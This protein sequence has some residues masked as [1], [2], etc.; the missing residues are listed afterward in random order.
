MPIKHVAETTIKWYDIEIT[1]TALSRQKY[2]NWGSY[3][4]TYYTCLMEFVDRDP[5]TGHIYDREIHPV[6]YCEDM[7]GWLYYRDDK[8]YP[9][10]YFKKKIMT[11]WCSVP[12]PVN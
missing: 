6:C 12:D 1:P 9:E 2:P 4:N 3:G 10:E 8:P 5:H 11:K 7:G